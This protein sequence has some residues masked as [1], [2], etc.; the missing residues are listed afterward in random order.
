MH[1]FKQSSRVV[2]IAYPISCVV[3]G[4]NN[5]PQIVIRKLDPV[6]MRSEDLRKIPLSVSA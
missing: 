3:L 6:A 2:A 1:I 4:A 5:A